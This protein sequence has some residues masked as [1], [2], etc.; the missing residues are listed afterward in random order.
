MGVLRNVLRVYSYIFEFVLCLLAIA[1]SGLTL[2]GGNETLLL[3]WL[4]WS[5]QKLLTWLLALGFFGLLCVLLAAFGKLRFLLFLF[6]LAVF[7]IL[8]RGLFFSSY[9]FPEPGA[10]KRALMLVAGALLA[11]IGAWPVA[12]DQRRRIS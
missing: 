5:G 10:L 9:A 12:R 1:V 2:L 7:V 8:A 11:A 6:S 4:P 3:G